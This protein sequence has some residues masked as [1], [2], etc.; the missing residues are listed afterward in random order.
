[1]TT[2][3]R[4]ADKESQ[5]VLLVATTDRPEPFARL[6]SDL[7]VA[8]SRVDMRVT[9]GLVENSRS[10]T[11]RASNRDTVARL[12][13]GGLD[14]VV[15]D[16]LPGGHPIG[17]ARARQRN[18]LASL[19]E[20]GARPALVWMLDDDLRLIRLV[21]R[22]GLLCR[23]PLWNPLGLLLDLGRRYDSPDVLVGTV[24]GDPPIPAMATWASRMSD[25]ASNLERML[26][27]GP[28]A[29]WPSDAST[30][31]RLTEPDY[32]YDYGRHPELAEPAFWL[33]RHGEQ[34]T[35]MA[36]RELMEE[37]R[38]LP[39][40]VALTR[41]LVAVET[42]QQQP[43]RCD[44]VRI[45][46]SAQVRGGNTVF[47]DVE[48]CLM[49]DYPT[50]EVAGVRTRRSD[51]VGMHLLSAARGVRVASS[52]FALLHQ[53]DRDM[54]HLPDSDQLLQHLVAD[55]LGAALTR[56]VSGGSAE[57]LSEFLR[58]RVQH[59]EAALLRLRSAISRVRNLA[60]G[61]PSWVREAG[62]RDFVDERDGALFWFE[63][64]VPGLAAGR[65]P[66]KARSSL[67]SRSVAA[68]L[69]QVAAGCAVS[70]PS[71]LAE[72]T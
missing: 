21:V 46:G 53:R 69:T 60:A 28:D 11:N 47:F 27:L 12:K 19:V 61:T 26:G 39:C 8:A 68:E 14:V 29:P 49:H 52:D 42:A 51:S 72:L 20:Q 38:H 45:L 32:Y 41:P 70:R 67:L 66:E 15:S 43:D 44:E 55:T 31:R 59:I 40:G 23:E 7:I 22:D 25:L 17:G 6:A 48:A 13:A 10:A 1:M 4:Y 64:N 5:V 71:E 33:P 65:L 56:A 37:A 63:Q 2:S 9:L 35:S 30:I 36:L 57:T 18:L 50:A 58:T 3:S 62:L 54:K 16:A 24:H 34:R